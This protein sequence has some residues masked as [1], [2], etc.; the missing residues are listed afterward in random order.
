MPRWCFARLASRL[1]A[2]S[3]IAVLAACEGSVSPAP[4]VKPN[5]AGPPKGAPTTPVSAT[6]MSPPGGGGVKVAILLPLSGPNADLGKAML[7]AAQLALFTT[8]SDKLTLIPR[9][10]TGT[11]DGAANAAKAVIAD[12]AK[13]ILGP[14]IADEV[15]AVRPIAAAANVNVIGFATKTEVAGGNVF[16]MGF[17]PKQ[18]V[19]REVSFARDQGLSR[20][21]ALAPNSP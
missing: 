16:L 7:D 10:T 13:L 11:A 14:L 8:G 19:V 2:F 5:A 4:V 18:E 3:L 20:F 15:V 12:G 17:L 1:A 9:D 6:P 21:A